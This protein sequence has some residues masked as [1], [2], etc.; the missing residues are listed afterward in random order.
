MQTAASNARSAC[1]FGTQAGVDQLVTDR[2]VDQAGGFVGGHRHRLI[3]AVHVPAGDLPGD[4]AHRVGLRVVQPD[5]PALHQLVE[6]L[7]GVDAR[8]DAQLQI[9]ELLVSLGRG[10][11]VRLRHQASEAVHVG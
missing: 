1:F 4:L 5:L 8:A 9:R 11:A 7:A 3:G 6:R 10:R 2:L